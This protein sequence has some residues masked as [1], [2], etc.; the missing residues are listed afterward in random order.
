MRTRLIHLAL[1]THSYVD[2]TMMRDTCELVVDCRIFSGARTW[3]RLSTWYAHFPAACPPVH[4]IYMNICWPNIPL[5]ISIYHCIHMYRHRHT[6]IPLYISIYCCIHMY[7]H[8]HRHAHTQAHT[9]ANRGNTTVYMSGKLNLSVY[10]T[11]SHSHTQTHTHAHT[12]YTT[13]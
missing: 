3:A 10:H 6:D 9:Q 12:G 5:Y 4:M 11:H 8:R 2:L 13:V 7:R 1:N